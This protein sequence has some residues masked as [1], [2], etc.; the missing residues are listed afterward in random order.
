MLKGMDVKGLQNTYINVTV[1]VALS[2]DHF[3]AN[4]IFLL[5]T[6]YLSP[7]TSPFL[8]VDVSPVNWTQNTSATH[9]PGYCVQWK[10]ALAATSCV[11]NGQ[12]GLRSCVDALFSSLTLT[13]CV[14]R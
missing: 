1:S 6:Y 7:L 9:T 11:V 8:V 13:Q 2:L 4:N 10:S 14:L 3:N 5:A 12:K